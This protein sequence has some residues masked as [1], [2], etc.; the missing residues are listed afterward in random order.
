MN[1]KLKVRGLRPGV[2]YI[3][4]YP[5]YEILVYVFNLDETIQYYKSSRFHNGGHWI[6]IR[7]LISDEINFILGFDVLQGVL[8]SLHSI[9]PIK[10]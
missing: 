2:G 1:K 8:S 4:I 7:N 9:I 10:L 3:L 6:W 5:M